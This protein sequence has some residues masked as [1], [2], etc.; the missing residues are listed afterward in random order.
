MDSGI[1]V[2]RCDAKLNTL[3][4]ILKNNCNFRQC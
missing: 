2:N 1:R 3:G 4:E